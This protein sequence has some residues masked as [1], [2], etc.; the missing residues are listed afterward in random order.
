MRTDGQGSAVQGSDMRIDLDALVGADVRGGGQRELMHAWAD[1][2]PLYRLNSEWPPARLR[3]GVRAFESTI[4]GG[5]KEADLQMSPN[6]KVVLRATLTLTSYVMLGWETGIHNEF[7][8]LWNFGMPKEQSMELVMFSQLYA[9][10]R[11]LGHVYR[12]IGDFLPAFG[13]PAIPPRAPQEAWVPDPE[14]F[15]SPDSISRRAR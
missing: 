3:T 7:W 8:A 5:T 10:M 13:P 2:G 15:P 14:A 12:A 11:G 6:A 4:A 9:G 1:R